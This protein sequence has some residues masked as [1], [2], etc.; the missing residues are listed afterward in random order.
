MFVNENTKNSVYVCIYQYVVLTAFVGFWWRR[1]MPVPAGA[2]DHRSECACRGL[3]VGNR[4]TF[5]WSNALRF[6]WGLAEWRAERF[7][8]MAMA[9]WLRMCDQKKDVR[10]CQK[11]QT[12]IRLAKLLLIC[13]R[14]Q[15]HTWTTRALWMLIV[16]AF[17]LATSGPPR[18]CGA[19]SCSGIPII[20]MGM[21]QRADSL[22][23][24]DASA[25]WHRR[26]SGCLD[27]NH[28]S[29]KC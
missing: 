22:G 27:E 18:S 2:S 20:A 21:L 11:M 8:L 4:S 10:N 12:Y 29:E 16:P 15:R 1:P 24:A 28:W 26:E 17:S 9:G 14:L 13:Q 19:S 23:C 5:C 25:V 3:G 7:R 6:C